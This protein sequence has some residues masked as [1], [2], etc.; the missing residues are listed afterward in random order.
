MMGYAFVA[1]ENRDDAPCLAVLNRH[2]RY[3]QKMSASTLCRAH[4]YTVAINTF[5]Q[6]ITGPYC[7]A[8]PNYYQPSIFPF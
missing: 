4:L 1:D 2:A 8:V 6:F 3:K 5:A 7:V